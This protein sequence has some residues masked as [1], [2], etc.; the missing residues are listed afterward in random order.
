MIETDKE[1][2]DRQKV[3][4]ANRQ[5]RYI[6]KKKASGK[7]KVINVRLSEGSHKQ[8]VSIKQSNHLSDMASTIEHLIGLK[9]LKEG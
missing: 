4:Q 7:V 1:Y 3:Q 5:K 6:D 2:R 8:L 9:Q